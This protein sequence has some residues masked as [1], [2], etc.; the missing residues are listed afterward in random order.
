MLIFL[1]IN[2]QE[3]GKISQEIENIHLMEGLDPVGIVEMKR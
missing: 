1:Q 2:S 3:I